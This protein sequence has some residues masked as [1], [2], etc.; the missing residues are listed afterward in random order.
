[1]ACESRKTRGLQAR[2][3]LAKA[4]LGPL[5]A[6][7]TTGLHRFHR[8]LWLENR[9]NKH[10]GE[11]AGRLLHSIIKNLWN[12]CNLRSNFSPHPRTGTLIVT[13]SAEKESCRCPGPS[14]K[15]RLSDLRRITASPP[16][17]DFPGTIPHRTSSRSPRPGVTGYMHAMI[18]RHSHRSTSLFA[19]VPRAGFGHSR[20]GASHPP[21]GGHCHR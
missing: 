13:K 15:T 14:L 17:H 12:P 8:G 4:R 1:M 7:G 10:D 11:L 19:P 20:A 21:I 5:K 18:W 2:L 16:T 6:G 3:N 9:R